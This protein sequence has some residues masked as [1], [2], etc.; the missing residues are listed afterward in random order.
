MTTISDYIYSNAEKRAK[1]YSEFQSI[2][3]VSL[4]GFWDNVTGFD[5]I[6]F[7]EFISPADGVSCYA[8]TAEKFGERSAALIKEL[9]V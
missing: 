4:R 7:D 8:A 3:A 1:H 9:L 6:K 2:F 5:V